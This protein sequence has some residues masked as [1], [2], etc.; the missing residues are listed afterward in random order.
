L[1]LCEFNEKY[2][3][4]VATPVA[5]KLLT[6]VRTLLHKETFVAFSNYSEKPLSR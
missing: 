3:S 4:F 6:Q 1:K 2:F 5:I